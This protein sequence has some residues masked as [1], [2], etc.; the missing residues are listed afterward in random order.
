M[1]APTSSRPHRVLRCS[2]FTLIE[3]LVV[4]VIVCI[5]AGLLLPAIQQAREA[6]R[7]VQCQNNLLQIGLALQNYSLAHGVLPPGVVNATGPIVATENLANYHMSWIVQVLPFLD[8][9]NEYHHVDFTRSAY[10]PENADVR[11]QPLSLLR[12]PSNHWR[13][14]PD[15]AGVHN[16]FETPIDVNQ[17]GVL[18]LNSSIRLRDVTDG[19]S[20]TMFVMEGNVE[21]VQGANAGPGS[22]LGWMSGTSSTLRNAVVWMNR[23]KPG[24]TPRYAVRA[25]ND[26]GTPMQQQLADLGRGTTVVGGPSSSHG[27]GF[28]TVMGDGAVRMVSCTVDAFVLR[29]LAHRADGEMPGEF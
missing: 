6:S 3:L 13:S 27:I 5:L 12:C 28:H 25:M 20:N 16:D 21:F 23:D 22:G 4:I 24:E 17:N 18:F 14:E 1:F 2:G 26:Y 7:R 11:K 19:C 8:R 29:N 15:Y 10:A 9:K